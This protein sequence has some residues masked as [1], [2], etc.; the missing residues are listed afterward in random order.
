MSEISSR[1]SHDAESPGQQPG[2]EAWSGTYKAARRI[3]ILMISI[4]LALVG[5]V[6]VF[7]PGPAFVFFWAALALLAGEFAWAR[8]WLRRLKQVASE[9]VGTGT[10]EVDEKADEQSSV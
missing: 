5:L 4:T 2:W 3:V 6:L 7:T 10:T 9:A 8:Q 1:N